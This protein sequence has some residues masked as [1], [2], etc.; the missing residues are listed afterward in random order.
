MSL[1]NTYNAEDLHD[2]E[3]RIQ[4][5]LNKMDG[6]ATYSVEPKFD[7]LSVELVYEK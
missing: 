4:K 2:W 5:F 7:G 6:T 3:E 1:E